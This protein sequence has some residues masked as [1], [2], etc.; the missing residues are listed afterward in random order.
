MR[1]DTLLYRQVHPSFLRGN[2]PTR[3]AFTPNFNDHGLLSVYNG[4]L[5]SPRDAWNHY[6]AVLGLCSAGVVAITVG[7]C[8]GLDVLDDYGDETFEEHALIDM[9]NMSNADLKRTARK[10]VTLAIMRGWYF[11]QDG[12]LAVPSP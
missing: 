7:E 4:D 1:A 10:L 2:T 8:V 5:I 3:Q 6:N 9:R 12:N 11:K